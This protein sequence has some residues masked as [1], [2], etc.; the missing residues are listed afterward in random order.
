VRQRRGF[1]WRHSRPGIIEPDALSLLQDQRHLGRSQLPHLPGPDLLWVH[2][3]RD[4]LF[5]DDCRCLHRGE[6]AHW[7]MF[8]IRV[9]GR[10]KALPRPA[11]RDR[12]IFSLTGIRPLVAHAPRRQK[13]CHFRPQATGLRI[14]TRSWRGGPRRGSGHL[15]QPSELRGSTP[16]IQAH[17]D[18]ARGVALGGANASG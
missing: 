7:F 3:P 10:W 6:R 1:R 11:L 8:P 5:V 17:S 16:G 14:F 13:V 18:V 12:G 2:R 9:S 4:R 15:N